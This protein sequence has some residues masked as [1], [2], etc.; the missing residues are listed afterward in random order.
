MYDRLERTCACHYL[1]LRQN[2]P[3]EPYSLPSESHLQISILCP[4][5]EMRSTTIVARKTNSFIHLNYVS[6]LWVYSLMQCRYPSN[7]VFIDWPITYAFV[8]INNNIKIREWAISTVIAV[9]IC[10]YSSIIIFSYSM[11]IHRLGR[12]AALL[13]SSRSPSLLAI[14][15]FSLIIQFQVQCSVQNCSSP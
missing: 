8:T 13:V 12:H 3:Q 9:T 1:I 5:H 10:P 6:A 2:M 15:S 7:S 14:G 11:R 4:I